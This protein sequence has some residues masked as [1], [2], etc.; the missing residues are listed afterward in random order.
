[1]NTYIH[2]T[3]DTCTHR[4][5]WAYCQLQELSQNKST[6]PSRVKVALNTLPATL[7]DTY[8]RM[9]NRIGPADKRD[10]MVLL[11][12]LAYAMSPLTLGELR[13][14]VTIRTEDE[15]VD[16][17]DEGDLGDSLNILSA[18]I[19]FS[20]DAAS[21]VSS[22]RETGHGE[23]YKAKAEV[24]CLEPNSSIRLAHSSVKEYLESTRI[25]ES[26]VRFFS[27]EAGVGHRFLSQS[28]LTYLMHYS[29]CSTE[30]AK[31]RD[32]D[33][34]SLLSYAAQRWHEHSR[35]Q[36][37][38]DVN[39]EVALL[40][41]DATRKHWL[42]HHSRYHPSSDPQDVQ[43]REGSNLFYAVDMGLR[44][45]AEALLNAGEDAND[46]GERGDFPLLAA[47]T[48]NDEELVKLLVSKGAN[49]NVQSRYGTPLE[50]AAL[51]GHTDI[52]KVLI[53]SSADVNAGG[54]KALFCALLHGQE[55]VVSLLEARGASKL[56]LE[57][58]NDALILA[59]RRLDK[60][61]G[62][63]NKYTCTRAVEMLL[64]RGADANARDAQP[65]RFVAFSEHQHRSSIYYR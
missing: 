39:R 36:S 49:M 53:D 25:L 32:L 35:L 56:T 19:V 59:R 55:S 14:A 29:K 43:N 23:L 54:G 57:Q 5:R 46:T 27:L 28:C 58:L 7:H 21:F 9:L 26:D 42:W 61:L 2:I 13:A 31:T 8:A 15:E 41:S 38:D 62:G 17:G 48:N 18:L 30:M 12:W 34:F 45:V 20:E 44:K 52:V 37:G 65:L 6:R 4:F 24:K 22:A 3:N 1:M 10:A 64:E 16:F 50:T 51:C 60:S 11:R 40:T 63:Y 33:K 47:T